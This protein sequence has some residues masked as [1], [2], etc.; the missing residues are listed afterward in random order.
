MYCGIYALRFYRLHVRPANQDCQSTE[1]DHRKHS[2]TAHRLST[3]CESCMPTACVTR[4]CR[5][6]ANRSMSPSYCTRPVLEQDLLRWP[7]DSESMHS[8]A[9][10][11]AAASVR[12]TFRR[13]KNCLKHPTSSS[14]VKSSTTSITCCTITF[15]L[16]QRPHKTTTCKPGHT[17]DNY[18]TILDTSQTVTSSPASCT[19]TFTNQYISSPTVYT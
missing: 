10:A 11:P 3:C 1:G 14:S 4:H 15:H 18:P 13:S 9:A 2:A 19:M 16:R 5:L 12:Q 17:A 7:T 6:S 8:S